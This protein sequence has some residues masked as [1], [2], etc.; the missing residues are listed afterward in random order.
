MAVG[1]ALLSKIDLTL[2]GSSLCFPQICYRVCVFQNLRRL[3]MRRHASKDSIYLVLTMWFSNF[4]T[5][6]IVFQLMEKQ[7]IF[8]ST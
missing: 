5:F 2:K 8:L 4:V 3:H 7:Q 1:V 6:S